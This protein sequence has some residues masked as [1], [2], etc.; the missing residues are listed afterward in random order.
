MHEKNR[1]AVGIDLGRTAIG[2]GLI[3]R[4]QGTDEGKR[5]HHTGELMLRAE[6]HLF[7]WVTPSLIK[8]LDLLQETGRNDVGMLGAGHLIFQK[9]DENG[10]STD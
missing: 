4:G 5:L 9:L 8:G 1:I 2:S 7:E 6:E 10:I 3:C